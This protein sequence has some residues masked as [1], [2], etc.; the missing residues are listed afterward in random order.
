M[1]IS[2]ERLAEMRRGLDGLELSYQS[3][4][5]MLSMIDEIQSLRA[6]PRGG[7]KVKGLEWSDL[8]ANSDSYAGADALLWY[9]I[10]S[11]DQEWHVMVDGKA[12]S[13]SR[14]PN[15]QTAKAAAQA[16]YE[17]RILSAIEQEQEPAYTPKMIEYDREGDSCVEFVKADVPTVTRGP[18]TG[19]LL[20]S[21]DRTEI[22]G[23]RVFLSP[24]VCKGKVTEDV[25]ANDVRFKGKAAYARALDI[26][27]ALI[28][29]AYGL[30]V[31]PEWNKAYRDVQRAA[32]SA[33]SQEGE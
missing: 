23:L 13:I 8:P 30:D 7:V 4:H 31:P 14:H 19:E 10:I 21:M 24:S 6:I 16:D 28:D 9:R 25:P 5:E 22:V 26:A 2:D 3:P 20:M 27:D 18:L 33:L 12:P 17:G 29:R 1:T 15:R 32:S 11:I